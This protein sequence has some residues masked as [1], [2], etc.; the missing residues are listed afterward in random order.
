[1]TKLSSCPLHMCVIT[2][3]MLSHNNPSLKSEQRPSRRNV[4]HC[5]RSSPPNLRDPPD[6]NSTDLLTD[7][8]SRARTTS[9]PHDQN[10]H[11]TYLGRDSRARDL[12]EHCTCLPGQILKKIHFRCRGTHLRNTATRPPDHPASRTGR[13]RS[14]RHIKLSRLVDGDRFSKKRSVCESDVVNRQ[15]AQGALR[16]VQDQKV[17][18][19]MD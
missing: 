14:S 5:S 16:G 18:D 15:T 13:N 6:Q 1:M 3:R 8:A 10:R 9:G 11:G 19:W 7:R 2:K 12:V 4:A 17:L